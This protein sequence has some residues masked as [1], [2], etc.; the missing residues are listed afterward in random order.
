MIRMKILGGAWCANNHGFGFHVCDTK[1]TLWR[2][3]CHNESLCLSE[4]L[5]VV[6]CSGSLI[7]WHIAILALNSRKRLSLGSKKS[8]LN[9][10][11]NDLRIIV[12]SS[13]RASSSIEWGNHLRL[14]GRWNG[15]LLLDGQEHAL[16][17][18]STNEVVVLSDLGIFLFSST[19]FVCDNTSEI[20]RVWI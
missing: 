13:C 6:S 3:L 19:F 8:S 10:S 15:A 16:L 2:L 9:S 20:L 11:S 18:L 17:R 5:F 7:E 14:I 12:I 1:V 4:I